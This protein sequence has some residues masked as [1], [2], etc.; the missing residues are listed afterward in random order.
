MVALQMWCIN[1]F[2]FY[3][4]SSTSTFWGCIFLSVSNKVLTVESK[5]DVKILLVTIKIKVQDFAGCSQILLILEEWEKSE[6]LK[7]HPCD[8]MID[9]AVTIVGS[10][11]QIHFVT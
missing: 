3:C 11:Q 5:Y 4:F 9:H 1:R 2:L 8:V 7:L 10:H 6:L